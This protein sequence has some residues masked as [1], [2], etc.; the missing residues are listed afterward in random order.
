MLKQE[1][2]KI[3][4]NTGNLIS[5]HYINANG[6]VEIYDRIYSRSYPTFV[7]KY[8]D[9]SNS[10]EDDTSQMF[11][12]KTTLKDLYNAV[13]DHYSVILDTNIRYAIGT[14]NSDV[15]N[16]MLVTIQKEPENFFL[17]NNGITFL[18][19]SCNIKNS[20]KREM[21]VSNGCIVNGGQ[22]LGV[23]KEYY[24]KYINTDE[25]NNLEKAFVLIRLVQ[26]KN[27]DITDS[28]VINL[29][30]Q[31]KTLKSFSFSNDPIMISLQREINE[32]THY[33]IEI[34]DNEFEFKSKFVPEEVKNKQK[35]DVLKIDRVVQIFASY[36]NADGKGN[37]VKN[38]KEKIITPEFMNKVKNE[39]TRENILKSIDK[40]NLVYE[41]IFAYRSSKKGHNPQLLADKMNEPSLK[42]NDY[43]FLNT[44]DFILLYVLGNVD[45]KIANFNCDIGKKLKKHEINDEEYNNLYIKV[46][47]RWL[48]EF[49]INCSKNYFISLPNYSATDISRLTK[50][51]TIHDELVNHILEKLENSLKIQF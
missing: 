8:S 25:I 30:K 39:F 49:I 7:L 34:K 9:I 14:G 42:L 46:E 26:L 16:G 31:N 24:D 37:T 48:I 29:N 20:S 51:R 33:F 21:T 27:T 6:I 5:V 19:S 47:E 43:I 1:V 11:I 44:A 35:K 17:Y 40:Y 10:M 45:R 2:E 36:M 3:E 13:K 18:C 4:K 23:I 41:Y 50:N 12:I 22:T 32:Q 15:N 28:V 38:S